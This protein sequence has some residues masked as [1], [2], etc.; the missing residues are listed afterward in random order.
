MFKG[1]GENMPMCAILVPLL[2][3]VAVGQSQPARAGSGEGRLCGPRC[4][5]VAAIALGL[6]TGS[7]DSF[8]ETMGPGDQAGY[9]LAQLDEAARLIGLKTLPVR[10]D[11][12][13]LDRV[14][15]PFA[16]VALTDKHFVLI[17]EINSGDDTLTIVDPPDQA[18]IPIDTFRLSYSGNML[19]LSSSDVVLLGDQRWLVAAV[20]AGLCAV[21][22]IVAT[23]AARRRAKRLCPRVLLVAAGLILTAA[24]G[25]GA[26][27]AA[28]RSS[29]AAVLRADP[30]HLDFGPVFVDSTE[31]TIEGSVRLV[32]EGTTA[33]RIESVVK[34]R[35]CTQARVDRTTI[36]ARGEAK[37]TT[38]IKVG[39]RPGPSSTRVTV[40]C[41]SES[42]FQTDVLFLW[43]ALTTM[44]VEPGSLELG[45]IDL[46]GPRSARVDLQARGITFCRDCR[47]TAES[48]HGL[49]SA[50]AALDSAGRGHGHAPREGGTGGE[51]RAGALELRFQSG[52]EPGDYSAG[53][54]VEL[55]CG[56]GVRSSVFLPVTWS[57]RPA[58]EVRPARLWGGVCAPGDVVEREVTV[59]SSDGSP[60]KITR[61]SCDSP[62]ILQTTKFSDAEAVS[63]TVRLGF[64]ATPEP[65]TLT[66]SLTFHLSGR[67]ASSAILP[68]S[69][70][71]K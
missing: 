20:A 18:R 23:Q 45:R 57:V 50:T 19:I 12:T 25:C 9:S 62:A 71:I 52:A 56:T 32:N 27:T 1:S 21:C 51:T 44:F 61:V 38:R 59:A 29:P 5:Y 64:K 31:Q 24:T 33:I 35:T 41:A 66:G 2:A 63:H 40:V 70:L 11:V 60:F 22:A 37:L 4:V 39:N 26:R 36:P 69:F 13:F 14:R 67:E 30:A 17:Q 42:T 54:A 68:V 6:E 43:Q 8:I 65:G 7:F 16:C 34:T 55:H 46:R 48:T 47:L 53:I 15:R 3:L 28:P 58:F 10:A 49:L